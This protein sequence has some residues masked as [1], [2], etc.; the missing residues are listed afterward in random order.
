[1]YQQPNAAMEAQIEAQFSVWAVYDNV[2][3]EMKII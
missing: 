2:N 1:M 3:Q